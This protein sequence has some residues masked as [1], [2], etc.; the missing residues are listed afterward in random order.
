MRRSV[1]IILAV[2]I[3]CSVIGVAP[4]TAAGQASQADAPTCAFPATLT[5]ATGE[6]VTLDEPPERVT[7]TNPSAAQIMWELD[8]EEQVVGLTQFA[9]YLDGADEREDVSATDFG[10]DVERTIATDP[11]LVLAPNATSEDTVRTLRESGLTVY[12]FPAATDFDDVAE[13]T[14]IIGQLTGNC[15]EAAVANAWMNA[16]V[17]AAAEATADAE[18]PGVVYPLDTEFVVGDNTFI[19]EII[20]AGGGENLAADAVDGYQPISAETVAELDPEVVIVTEN[21][22]FVVE[23]EPYASTAAVQ[24][25]NLVELDVN[26]LNQPA[27]GSVVYSVQNLTAQL[28]PDAYDESDF[29]SKADVEAEL[30]AGAATDGDNES[31][32]A[33]DA[34]ENESAS[35]GANDASG[36]SDDGAPGF[37]VV[38]AV[39]AVVGSLLFV[40]RRL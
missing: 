15:E 3:A 21:S 23:E 27:P 11:D 30:G 19:D 2:L 5:D 24:N 13:K 4:A 10:V 18:R 1:S 40:R 39:A 31:D 29:V 20:V 14:E 16:N 8:A 12:H 22:R 38:A 28:Y 34:D 25:D 33:N 32:G 9:M 6:E 17:D 35:D 26:Y 37:G 7:T 36:E